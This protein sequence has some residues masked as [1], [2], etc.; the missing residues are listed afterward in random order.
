M[1]QILWVASGPRASASVWLTAP[2]SEIVSTDRPQIVEDPHPK[3]DYRRDTE[4]DAKLVTEEGQAG[5]KCH[6]GDQAAEEDARLE[7]AGDVGLEGP[8]DRV[9]RGQQRDGCVARVC[10]GDGDRRQDPEQR[11][12]EREQDRDDDYLHAGAGVGA[13]VDFA[14]GDG[15]GGTGSFDLNAA[16]GSDAFITLM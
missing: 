14:P 4:I 7:R 3:S 10:D 12:E 2:L 15:L 5:S 8:E 6:V 13:G 11:A 1:D 16:A 9:E